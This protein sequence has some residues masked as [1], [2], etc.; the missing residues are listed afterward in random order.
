VKNSHPVYTAHA[1]GPHESSTSGAYRAWSLMFTW[2]S[3]ERPATSARWL[4]EVS[5]VRVHILLTY[6]YIGIL[7]D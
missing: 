5:V 7:I 2:F 1:D 3:V 4:P 6:L